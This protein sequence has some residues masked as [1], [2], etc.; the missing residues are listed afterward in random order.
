MIPDRPGQA[1]S[2]AVQ[3]FTLVEMLIALSIF[4]MITAAGVTLLSLTARTQETSDRLLAEVGELR[5]AGALLNADLALAAPRLYRD[6]DGRPQRAF[7]GGAGDA[8]LLL[9]FVRRG[10]DAGEGSGL[11]RVGYR[12]RDG[13]LERLSFARVDGGGDGIASSLIDGVGALRLRYRDAEG[14][15]R[16]RWDPSDPT[17]LPVAVEL[18]TTSESQGL[19]RQ[20]FLVGAGAGRR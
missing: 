4:A 3:G 16:E 6:R 13:R 17:R 15:W 10:Y 9:M 12:L 11:Q 7:A 19:V 1:G 5:R 20:L 14:E 2:A 18:V 8:P